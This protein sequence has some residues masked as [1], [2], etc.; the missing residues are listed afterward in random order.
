MLV[1]KKEELT[2]LLN[3][4]EDRCQRVIALD[5]LFLPKLFGENADDEQ[6]EQELS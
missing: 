5:E 3:Q 2:A 4:I 6:I 1:L